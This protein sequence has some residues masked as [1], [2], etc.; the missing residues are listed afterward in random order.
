MYKKIQKIVFL[1]HPKARMWGSVRARVIQMATLVTETL[2][3]SGFDVSVK[4]DTSGI[5]DALVVVHKTMIGPSTVNKMAALKLRN[6]VLV[7]DP[8]DGKFSAKDFSIYDAV[9][10]ASFAQMEWLTKALPGK[11]SYFVNQRLDQRFPL[12]TGS[13]KDTLRIGYFGA[14]ENCAHKDSLTGRIDLIE[15]PTD[16]TRW[17]NRLL[18]YSMHY[19]VRPKNDSIFKPFGKG[20]IAGR[21]SCPIIVGYDE[22]DGIHLLPEDY[23]FWVDSSDLES[24]SYVIEKAESQFNSDM[25]RYARDTLENVATLATD[26]N[27]THQMSVMI[28][29][30]LGGRK[31]VSK[32]YLPEIIAKNYFYRGVVLYSRIVRKI[33][34][35]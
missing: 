4:S 21:Y 35:A 33:K 30:L 1:Y 31:F 5:R 9:I 23:P 12:Y 8:I 16:S 7:A 27:I 19:A 6:C 11:N 26:Q 14:S 24:I 25:W 3:E 20:Y 22:P 17:M 10:S 13:E 32:T 29:E 18:D 28:S 15:T 34:S 2:I